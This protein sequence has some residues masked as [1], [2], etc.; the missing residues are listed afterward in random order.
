MVLGINK[1]AI[2]L[3][4]DSDSVRAVELSGTA[5]EPKLSV[6]ASVELPEGAVDEGAI[7]SPEAVGAAL[8]KLWDQ[9]GF[10][11][12]EL[13]LGIS[14]Q[15]VMVRY[16]TM[17]KVPAEKLDNVVRYQA[18]E[19]LPIPLHSAVLDYL[20]IGETVLESGPAL[21]VLLVAA[22]RE[23][24]NNFLEALAL[25][26]LEA[27]DIDVSSL[28]LMRTLPPDVASRTVVAVNVAHGLSHILVA[29]KGN[30]R[31]ARQ[32]AVKARDLCE[33]LSC[34]PESLFAGAAALPKK[35][36]A[37][38]SGWVKNLASELRSSIAYY[39]GQ[40]GSSE[41]E[42]IIL[43]GRG[44]AFKG[45]SSELKETLG[46]PVRTLDP[47]ARYEASMEDRA[48]EAM[49]YAICAG[50]ALRGLGV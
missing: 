40:D 32:V 50:L 12:R 16:A 38:I 46:L 11:S 22:Q 13:L 35:M 15:G 29:S 2:G 9:S 27:V 45:I 43:T 47:L 26:R 44:A 6:Y 14:N 33:S 4:L 31:L 19:Y 36:P 8:K 20:V 34:S 49:D 17:P 25:A 48:P 23:M 42:E 41:V 30:P 39:Q 28:A 1:K 37:A 24:L 7:T 21:E 18:Q 10:K 5:K 3:E